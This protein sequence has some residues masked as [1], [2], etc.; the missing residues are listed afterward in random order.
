MA[1]AGD[2]AAGRL[3]RD[4]A[5]REFRGHPSAARSRARPGRGQP[6]L[7][8]LRR[9]LP[10][11][12]P[13]RHRH[14]Q[15]HPQDRDRQRQGRGDRPS[16]QANIMGGA[17]ARVCPTEVLC[18][19]ACVRTAQ[20]GKPVQD[21][22]AAAL[23]HRLAARA[24]HPALH[25]RARHRQARRGRRRR[26]GRPRLRASRWRCWATTSRCSRPSAQA[27]RPQ[28]IRHRR[29]QGAGRISRSARSSSSSRI[30]GI[31][32]RA[33]QAL[34]RDIKLADL[35][36]DYRRGLPRHAASPASTRWQLEGE[37]MPGVEDAVDYIER[38]RQAADK[39]KLPV[40]R[41]IVVI[42]GGNT[43]IDIAVQA[44]R[45]GA[46]DVTMVYRR[47][48]EHMGA[49]GHEQ[50]FA[51]INGVTIKH[52]ARPVRL[53]GDDGQA[54]GSR[55]RVH[56]AR[57]QRPARWHRRALH[58]A[59]PTWCSRRSASCSCPSRCGTARASCSRSSDGQHRRR[60]RPPDL[61]AGR[62]GRRRLR[63]PGRT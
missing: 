62:L 63:R 35:R 22:R 16:S 25:A 34:G 55:V 60:R 40:G 32:C 39:A 45:L 7:F 59:A 50:E 38:L 51:Q 43:A 52:W 23:R 1:E 41:R 49:T 3:T 53:I 36:R 48:P 19:G 30:G 33:G 18:E 20:E 57:R 2:I 46:E 56:A 24:R 10:R 37:T 8:L 31:E 29:L 14:P 47:G 27:R 61:A 11:G 28:R 9:A 15:L 54:R 58:A 6:L 17:C 4:A 5:D 21:R 12:L 42:G 13:D 44:K 26:P